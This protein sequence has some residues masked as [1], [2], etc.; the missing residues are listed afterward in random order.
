MIEL[1]FVE[2]ALIAVMVQ[3]IC[4]IIYLSFTV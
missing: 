2:S 1:S 4:I 3:N